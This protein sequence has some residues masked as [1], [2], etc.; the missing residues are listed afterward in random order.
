MIPL[1]LWQRYGW[2]GWSHIQWSP[3]V[4]V[5]GLATL[6]P[7]T[8]NYASRGLICAHGRKNYVNAVL[9]AMAISQNCY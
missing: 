5:W 3:V 7:A 4:A 2:G 6:Y 8:P 1:D 9:S